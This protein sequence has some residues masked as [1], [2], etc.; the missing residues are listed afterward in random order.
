M[1]E[2]SVIPD[3]LYK[4]DCNICIYLGRYRLVMDYD[5]YLCEASKTLVARWGSEGHQY[6]SG[7]EHIPH[8]RAIAVAAR[9]ALA[10]Y[11]VI[12]KYWEM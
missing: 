10:Y 7:L 12:I 8:N 6:D 9:R 11:M 1:S 4:H 5:L 2:N 3:P